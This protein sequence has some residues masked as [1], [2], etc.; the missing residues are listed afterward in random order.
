MLGNL[1]VLAQF[2]ATKRSLKCKIK[3]HPEWRWPALKKR[4]IRLKVP[5]LA[6]SD[7][8]LLKFWVS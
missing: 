2:L 6:E 7:F 3:L 8:S 4:S 1:T 5:I